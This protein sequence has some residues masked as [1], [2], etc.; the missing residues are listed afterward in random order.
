MC[1]GIQTTRCNSPRSHIIY[2]FFEQNNVCQDYVKKCGFTYDI[3]NHLKDY[4][5]ELDSNKRTSLFLKIF[6]CI[7]YAGWEDKLNI[8]IYNLIP[9]MDENELFD[10]PSLYKNIKD[11]SKISERKRKQACQVFCFHLGIIVLDNCEC[12]M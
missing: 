7:C 1:N 10:Y 12:F 2:N 11:H 6:E 4:D 5:G 8:L 9:I 3:C